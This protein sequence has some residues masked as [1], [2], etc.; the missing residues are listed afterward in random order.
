MEAARDYQRLVEATETCLKML[1]CKME[2]DLHGLS[3]SSALAGL[4]WSLVA[5][6]QSL[7]APTSFR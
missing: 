3:R 4:A 1:E 2:G 5:L 7:V 6:K